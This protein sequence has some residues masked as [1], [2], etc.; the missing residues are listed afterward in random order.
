MAV[1][2][3]DPL[4]QMMKLNGAYSEIEDEKERMDIISRIVSYGFSWCLLTGVLVS[5]VMDFLGCKV[6]ALLGLAL[7]TSGYLLLFFVKLPVAYYAAGIVFGFGYQCILNSHMIIGCL[8]PKTPNLVL[9]IIGAGPDLSLFFPPALYS[10]A[11]SYGGGSRGV[12]HVVLLYLGAF[13]LPAAILDLFLVPWDVFLSTEHEAPRFDSHAVDYPAAS[14]N[15]RSAG[16]KAGAVAVRVES[17]DRPSEHST[18][19]DSAHPRNGVK[20][21][22]SVAREIPYFQH[23]PLLRQ[24]VTPDYWIFVPF[25]LITVLRKKYIA[26]AIRFIFEEI[27]TSEAKTSASAYTS[28]YNLVV[29]YGF[30]PAI[31]WGAL[32]DR[33]GIRSLMFASNTFAVVYTSLA[34]IPFMRLQVVTVIVFIVYQSFVFGQVMAFC[35]STYGFQTLASLQGIATTVFGLSSLFMDAVIYPYI[36]NVLKSHW[37]ANAFILGLSVAAYIFPTVLTFLAR[38]RVSKRPPGTPAILISVHNHDY[39]GLDVDEHRYTQVSSFDTLLPI[40]NCYERRSLQ[41]LGEVPARS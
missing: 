27:D 8:F 1:G 41:L 30:I 10:F 38:A 25:A 22:S 12:Q 39:P 15:E 36:T 7:H 35:A 13:V 16:E 24:L 14:S 23:L 11:N 34:L 4:Q 33:F 28:V 32:V 17:V 31:L 5:P 37:K 6:T 18:L 2:A 21:R 19:L 29:P 20:G 3:A 40:T 26:T 9:A